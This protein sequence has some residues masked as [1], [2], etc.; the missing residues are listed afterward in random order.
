MTKKQLAEAIKKAMSEHNVD[1]TKPGSA[2]IVLNAM[3]TGI[4]NAIAEY[5]KNP[6]G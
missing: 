6:E 3:S 1:M 5:V 4:A 2:D